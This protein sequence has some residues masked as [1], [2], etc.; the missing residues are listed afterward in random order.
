MTPKQKK[1]CDYYLET[2]NATEAAER[3]GYNPKTAKQTGY[4]NLTKPY[5]KAYIDE[6]T[7][8]M[9]NERIATPEEVLKYFTSV[10]RGEIKD[11]FDLDAPLTERTKAADALAKRFKFYDKDNRTLTEAEKEKERLELEYKKLQNEKL[12]AEIKTITGGGN[13]TT[14]NDGFIDAL[15]GTSQEDW[16]DD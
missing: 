12:K 1:F 14:V 5:I 9:D 6:R 7:R 8:Q 2:G 10:M 11:Q 16:E 4:E 13:D 3:A 15:K